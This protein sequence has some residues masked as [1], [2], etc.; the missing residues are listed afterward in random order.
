MNEPLGSD[1]DLVVG[2]RVAH[3]NAGDAEGVRV[4]LAVVYGKPEPTSAR[5]KPSECQADTGIPSFHS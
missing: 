2:G 4:R 3:T 5:G 1:R